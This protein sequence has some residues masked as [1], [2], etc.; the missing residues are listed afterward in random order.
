MKQDGIHLLTIRTPEGVTFEIPLAGPTRRFLAFLIDTGVV[1]VMTMLLAAFFGLAGFVKADLAQ[2]LMVIAYFVLSIGYGIVMEWFWRGKTLGKFVLNMRVMDVQGLRLQF[3]QIVIRNLLR[4]VDS[5]PILY[6]VGGA[7]MWFSPRAQRLGD[8]AANTVVVR[9]ENG[10]VPDVAQLLPDKYNSFRAHPHIE[11][12]LR[13]RV[14][15]GEAAI[16]VQ[17]LLR[18][19]MLDP[20]ARVAVYRELAEHFRKIASFPEEATL[21]LTDEQYLRNVVDCVFRTR[22]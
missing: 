3:S 9:E 8:L 22:G 13:Q 7:A 18:R 10:V 6:F 14:S 21:G 16:L 17:A 1:L 15:P 12:R 2:G 4:V 5:L 20:D 19:E 11:A